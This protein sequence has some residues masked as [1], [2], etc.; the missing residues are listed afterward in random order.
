VFEPVAPFSGGEK[1][2]LVLALTVY[3][4]PNLL[5]LDEPTN[6]LD[7]EMRQALAV[8]LQEFEGAL[9][10]VSH[11]RHLLNTVAD[12]FRLVADGRALP[13]DGDLEDY[14]RW[15]AAAPAGT[16]PAVERQAAPTAVPSPAAAA[17]RAP[18]G[19]RKQR[20][21]AEAERRAALSPLRAAI[22]EHE[23]Q[24]EKLALERSRLDRELL[25]ASN[26]A[27]AARLSSLM[28]DQARLAKSIASV[29]AAWLQANEQLEAL[30]A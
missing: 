10:L 12:E 7:L 25:A 9:V 30:K 5:L 14:A 6:H 15:L 20:K 28:K 17:M 26:A 13:F 22:A 16:A 11:D 1:A 21:R 18:A 19:E 29:E 4:R 27:D 8:A 2:R 24:L 23:R 3:Q